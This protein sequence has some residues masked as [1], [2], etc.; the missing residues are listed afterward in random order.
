MRLYLD[1]DIASRELVNVLSAAGHDVSRPQDVGLTGRDDPIQLTHA[2]ANDRIL[3][4]RNHND[5]EDLHD[6]VLQSGG[7]HPGIIIVRR[8]N[9]PRRDLKSR[10][11]RSAL[12][13][14]ASSGIPLVGAYTVLNHYR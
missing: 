8:E 6:L 4:S 3:L 14:L 9:N 10:G 1:E 5:F 11:I 7:S 13:K 12:A 2:I